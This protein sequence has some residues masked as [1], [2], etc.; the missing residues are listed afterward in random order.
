MSRHE[1]GSFSHPRTVLVC[2]VTEGQ[3]VV[4]RALDVEAIGSGKWRSSR[5]PDALSSTMTLPAAIL[6]P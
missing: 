2:A 4:D 1:H 6:R 3:V 5:L